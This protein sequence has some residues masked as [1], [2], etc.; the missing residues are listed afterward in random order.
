[1][2]FLVIQKPWLVLEDGEII[3]ENTDEES[4][5]DDFN[6]ARNSVSEL[7][8]YE[9]GSNKGE[10]V[11]SYYD[12]SGYRYTP[13]LIDDFDDVSTGLHRVNAKL[14]LSRALLL[15]IFDSEEINDL[16]HDMSTELVYEV[17]DYNGKLGETIS[18]NNE[19]RYFAVDNRLYPLGG[20]YYEDYSYH[21]GQT[22]GIFHAPT[23]LSGLD[24]ETYISSVY[25]T[26][27]GM[28]QLFL[29]QERNMRMNIL[30]MLFVNNQEL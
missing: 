12:I 22:T 7:D 16:Y 1:M 21:Q 2:D 26:Q 29:E 24:T 20:Q 13:D 10:L 30:T 28:D 11:I 9:S 5:I 6:D 15:Q 18:R 8:R 23:S 27:R 19:I 14:A 3:S 25:Q 4:A 17:Q